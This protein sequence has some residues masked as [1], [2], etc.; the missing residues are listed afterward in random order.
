MCVHITTVNAQSLPSPWVASDIGSPTLFGSTVYSSG[1]FTTVAGGSGLGG[2]TWAGPTDQ[3]HFVSQRV[4]G[5]VDVVVRV[6]SLTSLGVW[7][8]AGVMIRSSLAADSAHAMAEV[9]AGRGVQF[10]RRL[11]DGGATVYSA[12]PA[13]T[14]PVW[15]RASRVGTRV[16]AYSST[17]GTTWTTLGSDT[18]ALDSAAYVGLAVSSHNPSHRTTVQ[19]SDVRVGTP[20]GLPS[21]Q[22]AIDIGSPALAGSTA[23]RMAPTPSLREAPTSGT[24][25]ISSISSTSRLLATS[26]SSP[27]SCR[28]HG[29]TTGARLA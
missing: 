5:D 2:G 27:A 12:G 3:I 6:D 29:R 24:P 21:T 26:T 9:T 17:D 22:R 19:I 13:L 7:T 1:V 15:L 23:Y 11:S 4:T 8:E 20:A 18:I 14:A 28:S 16:T 10:S 25:P